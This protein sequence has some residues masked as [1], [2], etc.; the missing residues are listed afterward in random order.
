MTTD[1]SASAPPAS[2]PAI[3]KRVRERTPP[4]GVRKLPRPVSLGLQILL[5]AIVLLLWQ[6]L[7][8]I[9]WVSSRVT[10]LDRF[11][12]SSP[13]RVFTEI[14]ELLS[15]GVNGLTVWPYLWATLEATVLG[16]AI[17]L[18]LGALVG[19][20]LSN[21][22]RFNQ[23]IGPFIVAVN[24]MPR[25]A[26]VPIIVIIVGPT[27]R[28]SI[29]S[30]VLVVFFLGF[31]NAIEG[32]RSVPVELLSNAYLLGANNREQLLRIRVPFVL[33]WTFAA[34]PNAI[35]FGLLTVVTTEVITG[36]KGMGALILSATTNVDSTLSFAVVII[37]SVVGLVLHGLASLLRRRVL[38]WLP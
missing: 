20:A 9:K 31:F 16:A 24:S 22:V 15:T 6:Y 5:L 30:A 18:A 11:Y 25:I 19:L 29:I 12:V 3:R 21:A 32:G 1:L 38:H 14:R 10:F 4:G 35:A 13:T 36:I 27:I 2:W 8:E 34:M 28:A 23:V 33:T 37:L 7:P 26:L 17:G